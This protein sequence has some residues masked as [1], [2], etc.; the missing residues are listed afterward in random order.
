MSLVTGIIKLF[1]GTKAEK[2]RKEI[3]PYVDKIQ[4]VYPEIDRLSNDELRALSEQLKREIREYIQA[5]EEK[6]AELKKQMEDTT[7]SIDDKERTGKELDKLEK[8]IDE[9]IEKKLLEIL[10]QAFS[11][12]K[13]TARRFTENP[14]IEVTANDFDRELA[15]DRDFVRIEGDKAIY[16]NSWMAGGNKVTWDMVHYDSQLFGGVVLHLGKIA[17]MATG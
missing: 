5:D 1:F 12:V 17:E 16:S 3:Q 9:K 6:V 14:E 10:P 8:E 11:I 4:A 15:T 13:S 2:D 7:V